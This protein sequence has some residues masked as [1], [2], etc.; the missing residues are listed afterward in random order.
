[1]NYQGVRKV[2]EAAPLWDIHRQDLYAEFKR[3]TYY[4]AFLRARYNPRLPREMGQELSLRE[5]IY[6]LWG[7]TRTKVWKRVRKKKYYEKLFE[8]DNPN[9]KP[10]TLDLF[11]YYKLIA[12]FLE[13]YGITKVDNENW[14]IDSTHAILKGFVKK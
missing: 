10:S 8:L 11:E 4:Y 14:K 2:E 12:F 9:T 5:S 1:L 6:N 3:A 13:E 7:M